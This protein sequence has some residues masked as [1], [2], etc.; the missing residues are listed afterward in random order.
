MTARDEAP[1]SKAEC[2]PLIGDE[3]LA[4]VGQEISRSVGT[5]VKKEFQRWAA[6][7]GDRN[8]LYFDDEYAR[9]QG[10]R[11]AVMPPMYLSYVTAGV[12]ELDQLRPDGIPLHSGTGTIPLPKCPRRMAGGDNVH[13][14]E[15]VYADDVITSVRTLVDLEQK[16]GRSGEFVL[17]RFATTFTRADGTVVATTVG[18]AIA[19]PATL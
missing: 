14:L 11:E 17:M 15:P 1:G 13:F 7:V 2:D 9:S 12:M 18:S 5:V 3:A 16:S 4:L 8:P 6:A 19:R 10:Y